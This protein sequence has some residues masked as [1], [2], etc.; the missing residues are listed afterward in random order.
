MR[1]IY[2]VITFILLVPFIGNT[3]CNKFAKK[4]VRPIL[5]EYTNVG[6]TL[7]TISEPGYVS[8]VMLTF[9][10]GLDYRI[11]FG[12]DNE[13]GTSYFVIMDTEENHIYSSKD[14][15]YSKTFDFSTQV[16]RQLIVRIISPEVYSKDRV[17]GCVAIVT[18]YK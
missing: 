18:G 15:N 4:E 10:S 7:S 2:L 12:A 1:A 13:I 3:Q 9:F 8:D 17:M 14:D 5:D 16:T 11:A 6:K